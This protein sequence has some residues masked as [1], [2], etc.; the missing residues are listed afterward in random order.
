M[1]CEEA[2]KLRE[3]INHQAWDWHL[4]LNNIGRSY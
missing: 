1:A 2:I 4:S 3:E